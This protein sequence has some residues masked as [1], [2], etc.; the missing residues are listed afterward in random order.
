MKKLLIAMAII[1]AAACAAFG[2]TVTIT[3]KTVEYKRPKPD[4]EFRK[5]FTVTYPKVSGVSAALAAKIE[6]TISYEDVLSLNLKD[7]MGESQWLEE[8]TFDVGF[9]DRGVLSIYLSQSGTAAYPSVFGKNVVVD[10]ATGN[11]VSAADVFGNL[12]KLAEKCSEM[13]K[14]EIADQLKVI[15]KDEPDFVENAKIYFADAKFTRE[16]LEGFSVNAD[17]VTFVYDY[18][19]PHVAQALEPSGTYLI[20]WSNL[21]PF[22]LRQGL[23]GKFVN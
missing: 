5:S 9:N 19:F 17:G 23:L 21:K 22:V 18:G 3:P 7:E 8:A 10:L 1:V 12:D 16:N 2:Q 20:P 11:A 14:K 15:E 13:Q 4:N 6:K